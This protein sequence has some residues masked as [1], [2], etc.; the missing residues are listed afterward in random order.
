MDK[1]KQQ[2]NELDKYERNSTNNKNN[3]DRLNMILSV[4]DRIYKFFEYKILSDK[5]SVELKLPKWVNVN[6]ERFNNILSTISKAK[7]DGLKT[8]VDGREITLG[9]AESLLKGAARRKINGSQFQKEYNIVD[10]VEITLQ[11]SMFTRSQNRMV[12]VLLLLGEITKLKDKKI[13]EQPDTTDMPE[14]ESEEP[15]GQKSSVLLK[16]LKSNA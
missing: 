13:D 8:N 16:V 12:D 2:K 5:Q 4:I 11:K 7:N 9:N 3:N 6:R 10:D 1:I 14:L 15:A